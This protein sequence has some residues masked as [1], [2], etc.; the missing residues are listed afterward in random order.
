[1]MNWYGGTGWYQ[2][3]GWGGWFTMGIVM[4]LLWGL[5][6][7]GIVAL[8]R[9]MNAPDPKASFRTRPREATTSSDDILA[10]RFAHGELDEE[11]YRRRLA[12][13]RSLQVAGSAPHDAQVH[14]KD[15]TVA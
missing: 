10:K 11:E 6:V 2:G 1:M 13:L 9:S 3:M 8:V 7:W 15:R 12:I 4:I 14:R 5:V